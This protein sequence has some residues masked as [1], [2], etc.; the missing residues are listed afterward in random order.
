M[1]F[2]QSGSNA[3]AEFGTYND[4]AGN[5][6]NNSSKRVDNLSTEFPLVYTGLSLKLLLKMRAVMLMVPKVAKVPA[7]AL[8]WSEP[9]WA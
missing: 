5:Q 6:T 4:V 3:K 8:G 2:N 7:L 1:P 9:A